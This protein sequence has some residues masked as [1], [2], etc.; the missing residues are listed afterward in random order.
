MKQEVCLS[1][2]PFSL[3][4]LRGR[5]WGAHVIL[6][7]INEAIYFPANRQLILFS[8]LFADLERSTA[9]FGRLADT[10]AMAQILYGLALRCVFNL[11][12]NLFPSRNSPVVKK[13]TAVERIVSPHALNIASL[14]DP[15]PFSNLIN[16]D[17][18]K[19]KHLT[20]IQAW[21]GHI[22]GHIT[23]HNLPLT[24]RS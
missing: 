15:V 4:F 18:L 19:P 9:M 6:E 21:M 12:L 2:F 11:S 23:R 13:R 16:S 17:K 20:K 3:F 8:I 7:Y 24:R 10:N 5:L 1:F 14:F 22:Q